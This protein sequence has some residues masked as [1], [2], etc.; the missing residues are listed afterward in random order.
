MGVKLIHNQHYFNRFRMPLVKQP[1]D[2]VR[3]TFFRPL[4]ECLHVPPTGQ[5]FS[6]NVF[7]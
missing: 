1:F 7:R 3:P 5:W 4:R 6:K 2:A